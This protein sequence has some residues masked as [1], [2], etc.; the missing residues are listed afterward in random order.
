MTSE[1]SR[2]KILQSAEDIFARQG[3]SGT[4]MDAIAQAAGYNKSLIYQYFG[5]KLGLYQEVV[6][7]LKKDIEAMNAQVLPQLEKATQVL[8]DANGVRAWIELGVNWIFNFYL[9]HPN[10]MR[11]LAWEAAEGWQTFNKIW[12]TSEQQTSSDPVA[13]FIRAAQAE[14]FIHPDLDPD[15]LFTTMTAMIL[16]YHLSISR[17]QHSSPHL[18]FT[19]PDALERARVHMVA[20]MGHGI[21]IDP[22]RNLLYADR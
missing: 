8:M 15:L 9:E 13:S 19:S 20:L 5:D 18:D 22:Q 16:Q 21:L 1:E 10:M 12:P 7:G 4:R 11:I 2:A 14:G 3:F 6:R 17:Y